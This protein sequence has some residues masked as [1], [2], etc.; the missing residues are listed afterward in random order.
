MFPGSDRTDTMLNAKRTLQQR[1][2]AQGN[3]LAQ[4]CQRQKRDN[5]VW[6][7]ESG[8]QCDGWY[9]ESIAHEVTHHMKDRSKNEAKLRQRVYAYFVLF[10]FKS[11]L[12]VK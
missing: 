3:V 7:R 4:T 6:Q 5:R 11:R 12:K 10:C 1:Q 8:G 2:G 9:L